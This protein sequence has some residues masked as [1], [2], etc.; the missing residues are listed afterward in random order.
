MET[1]ILAIWKRVSRA[2]SPRD[3]LAGSASRKEQER[4]QEERAEGV[5]MVRGAA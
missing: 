3:A 5:G 1:L 4:R 2:D